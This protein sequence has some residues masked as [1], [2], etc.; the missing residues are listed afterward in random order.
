[1]RDHTRRRGADFAVRFVL[2][3]AIVKLRARRRQVGRQVGVVAKNGE[4]VVLALLTLG[5]SVEL[6]SLPDDEGVA[7]LE[8]E[9]NGSGCNVVRSSRGEAVLCSS[10]LS[11]P[12]KQLQGALPEAPE[13]GEGK[14]NEDRARGIRKRLVLAAFALLSSLDHSRR[15]S[16]G[17]EAAGSEKMSNSDVGVEENVGHVREDNVRFDS[18]TLGVERGRLSRRRGAEPARD[19]ADR[20]LHHVVSGGDATPTKGNAGEGMGGDGGVKGTATQGTGAVGWE[21]REG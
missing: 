3:L 14:W 19:L 9:G 6:T 21:A 13:G 15:G 1:M 11:K 10:H 20:M 2:L 7:F 5:R 8:G 4:G 18:R 17:L 12:V 16:A